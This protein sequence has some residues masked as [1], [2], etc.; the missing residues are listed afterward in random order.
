MSRVV[1]ADSL[2]IIYK[3][4]FLYEQGG[5]GESLNIIYKIQFQ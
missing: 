1:V 4:Q 5:G 3:I 2:N